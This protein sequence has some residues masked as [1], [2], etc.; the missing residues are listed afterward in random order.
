ME[1]PDD[2]PI[3]ATEVS[4]L[5]SKMKNSDITWLQRPGSDPKE[6]ISTLTLPTHTLCRLLQHQNRDTV[7]ISFCQ[8]LPQNEAV[9][10]IYAHSNFTQPNKS[11]I[12]DAPKGVQTFHCAFMD[13]IILIN[14]SSIGRWQPS[15]CSSVSEHVQ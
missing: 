8:T 15:N 14:C 7:L 13:N 9:T 11:Y 10:K 5:L 4:R 12:T 6:L 3:C 1:V 2:G